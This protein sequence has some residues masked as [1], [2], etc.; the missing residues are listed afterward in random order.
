MDD[1]DDSSSIV[2]LPE[3][4]SHQHQQIFDND[5]EAVGDDG[6]VSVASAPVRLCKTTPDTSS[7]TSSG[8]STEPPPSSP[9]TFEYTSFVNASPSTSHHRALNLCLTH[10]SHDDC[11]EAFFL[12]P[13]NLQPPPAALAIRAISSAISSPIPEEQEK[14][15]TEQELDPCVDSFASVND[16]SLGSDH[17]SADDDLWRNRRKLNLS[18]SQNDLLIQPNLMIDAPTGIMLV[19]DRMLDCIDPPTDNIGL[20]EE[21]TNRNWRAFSSSHASIFNGTTRLLDDDD[22]SISTIDSLMMEFSASSS[23]PSGS[24]DV[25]PPPTD[26][27]NTHSSAKTATILEGDDELCLFPCWVDDDDKNDVVDGTEKNSAQKSRPDGRSRTRRPPS[28]PGDLSTETATVNGEKGIEE[29]LFRKC[30][31]CYDGSLKSQSNRKRNLSVIE[32]SVEEVDNYYVFDDDSDDDDSLS[33]LLHGLDLERPF[34]E[35]DDLQKVDRTFTTD[36]TSLSY[37]S[38]FN[39]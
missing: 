24:I 5:R 10:S 25:D 26:F 33:K 37:S 23:L 34:D 12:R 30:Q 39:Y 8:G 19:F 22:Q 32:N 9:L 13:L 16:L 38:S 35:N 1:N 18:L 4:V 27:M 17:D 21:C 28:T 11:S 36:G 3:R 14:E 7:S 15:Q 2:S 20:R 6:D 29:A 31:G